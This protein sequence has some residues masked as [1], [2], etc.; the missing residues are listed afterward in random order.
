[1]FQAGSFSAGSRECLYIVLCETVVTL[2]L[3]H[4]WYATEQFRP[5]ISK[6]FSKTFV[7]KL[8]LLN[9]SSHQIIFSGSC[10]RRTIEYSVFLTHD[11]FIYAAFLQAFVLP[12]AHCAS[13]KCHF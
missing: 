10:M 7:S 6:F 5:P 9:N 11:P 3:S 13:E 12:Q 8:T 2:G 1:M 4:L